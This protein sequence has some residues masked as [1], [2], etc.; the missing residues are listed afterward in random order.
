MFRLELNRQFCENTGMNL[1]GPGIFWS[2]HNLYF[3]VKYK[4]S[5]TLRQNAMFSCNEHFLVRRLYLC[6]KL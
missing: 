1:C 6:T 4:E 5:P 2:Q 3:I